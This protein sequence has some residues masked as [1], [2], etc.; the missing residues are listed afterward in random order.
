ML[1]VLI[2]CLFATVVGVCSVIS[3]DCISSAS[4]MYVQVCIR[5]LVCFFCIRQLSADILSYHRAYSGLDLSMGFVNT[6]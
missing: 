3:I 6:M 5:C 1:L 2:D 4:C